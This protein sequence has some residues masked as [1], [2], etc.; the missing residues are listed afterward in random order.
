MTD[1]ISLSDFTPESARQEVYDKFSKQLSQA[2][3]HKKD[4]VESA[5]K[6][7]TEVDNERRDYNIPADGNWTDDAIRKYN[8]GIDVLN[9]VTIEK[10]D[11]KSNINTPA[12]VAPSVDLS[13]LESKSGKWTDAEI[14]AYNMQMGK[15]SGIV[16]MF[17]PDY[18]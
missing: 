11:T 9:G 13:E 10:N 15:N 6:G 7:N 1:P 8:L 4:F 2:G 3:I 18:K 14:D 16:P 17:S 5:L 12:N